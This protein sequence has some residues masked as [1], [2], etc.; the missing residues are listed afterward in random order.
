MKTT[1][2][3]LVCVGIAPMAG[4]GA[5]LTVAEHRKFDGACEH[6]ALDFEE[7]VR[8]WRFGQTDPELD[9]HFGEDRGGRPAVS[10][11]PVRK[12]AA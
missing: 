7:R 12:A 9:L 1:T 3:A 8:A 6:C 5:E 4:C 2:R 10:I 11:S